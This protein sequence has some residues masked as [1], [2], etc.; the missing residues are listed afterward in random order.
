VVSKVEGKAPAADGH[1]TGAEG[2]VVLVAEDNEVNFELVSALLEP[3]GFRII[4]ARD[5]A[6]AVAAVAENELD[7]LILDL[8]LPRVSGLDVLRSVRSN[9]AT[10]SL[11]V[12]VLTADAM[13]GTH[14]AVLAEGATDYLTKPFDLAAFRGAV[15]RILE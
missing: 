7:L 13:A 8:H 10:G 12:L 4:W 15:A 14:A 3:D 9:P 5:G 11:P 2:R 1:G 6:E